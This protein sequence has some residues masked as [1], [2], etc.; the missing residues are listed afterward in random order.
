M[1]ITECPY[2]QRK[3]SDQVP[4]CPFCGGAEGPLT[5]GWR[6][7]AEYYSQLSPSARWEEWKKLSAEQREHFVAAWRVLNY[8]QSQVPPHRPSPVVEAAE[9][10][11]ETRHK[12]ARRRQA[13]LQNAQTPPSRCGNCGGTSFTPLAEQ[14]NK[15]TGCVLLALGAILAPLLVGIIIIIWAFSVMQETTRWWICDSCG[16]RLPRGG[17]V[18]TASGWR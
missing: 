7:F 8:D 16:A 13:A 9:R 4:T 3:I 15:G 17:P 5:D 1:A 10:H 18:K 12:A 14:P 6:R 2:C 11:L